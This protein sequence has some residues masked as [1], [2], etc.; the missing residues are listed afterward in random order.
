MPKVIPRSAW[1]IRIDLIPGVREKLVDYC[2]KLPALICTEEMGSETEKEHV[3]ILAYLQTPTPKQDLTALLKSHFSDSAFSKSNFAFSEWESY[4]KNKLLEQ[5][6]CKGPSTAVRYEPI[7]I[8]KNWLEDHMEHHRNYWKIH[9]DLKVTKSKKKEIKEYD[10]F[11]VV[12][13]V[14][15]QLMEAQTTYEVVSQVAPA[16]IWYR[17]TVNELVLQHYR[18]KLNDNIAFPVIQGIS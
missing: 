5:Y 8:Y 16:D 14:Y 7:V 3:H 2:V 4:G 1:T 9:D 11:F 12:D 6:V 17:N 15:N 10:K 18:G 13:K